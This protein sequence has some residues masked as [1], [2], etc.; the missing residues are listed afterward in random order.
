MIGT[1]LAHYEIVALLGKGGMGEVYQARDTKLGREV[2]VK[3]LPAEVAADPERLARFRRE[4]KL[5]ASL[6][7]PNIGALYGIEEADGHFFLVME[8][9]EGEDLSRRL[10]AGALSVDEALSVAV[11][12]AEGLE[13]AHAKNIVHRDLKPANV[14]YSPS[15]RVKL[16]DFGLARAYHGDEA[17]ADP[18]MSPTITAAMTQQGMVLGTAAYM[19]PEQARGK[20]VDRQSDIWAFGVVLYEMLTTHRLFE[21]ETVSDSIG[22]ILHKDPEWARLPADTPP[23]VRQLLIRCLE[24]DR[25]A[26]LHDIAD[27]RATLVEARRDPTGS[28]LGMSGMHEP[29]RDTGRRVVAIALVTA[30]IGLVLGVALSPMLRSTEDATPY[31]VFDLGVDFEPGDEQQNG[32]QAALS[33]DGGAVVYTHAGQLWLQDLAEHEPRALE[34]TEHALAP[35]WAPDGEEI[36][37]FEGGRIWKAPVRGGRP[38]ALCEVGGQLAGGVGAHWGDDGRILFA[39]GSSGVR[40]VSELGGQ[41][42]VLIEPGEGYGDLHEPFALPDGRGVLFVSHPQ[43]RGPSVLELWREG[44]R[45]VL[46]EAATGDRLW[47]PVYDPAGFVLF[48]WTRGSA[49]EGLWALGFDLASGSVQSEPVLLEADASEA[50][51]ARDGTLVYV[52]NARR[53]NE[54]T[55]SRIAFSGERRENLTATHVGDLEFRLS[56]DGRW[57]AFTAQAPDGEGID[58]LWVRDLV[59]GTEVQLTSF[60]DRLV[61]F[62]Q[63]SSDS[64]QI[65]FISPALSAPLAETLVMPADGSQPWSV[66]VDRPA[67]LLPNGDFLVTTG[68]HG[69]PMLSATPDTT[70]VWLQ[71]GNDPETRRF[72]LGGDAMVFPSD[73]SPDG[74]YLLYYTG[75]QGSESNY[76]TRYPEI[77]G[78]W[79]VSTGT[80]VNAETFAPD[81]SAIYYTSDDALY[82]V[83]F[84]DGPTPVLGRPE[85]VGILPEGSRGNIQI[86][87]DNDSYLIAVNNAVTGTG[88]RRGIK[89]VQHWTAKLERR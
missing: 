74:R 47:A 41:V 42:K 2:A 46:F 73:L 50:T 40:S 31:R 13:A 21:G 80:D 26:R 61:F 33:P 27:A 71:R 87:P 30:L 84:E 8:L 15:G 1:Q 67:N 70:E 82:R 88:N 5:L 39:T 10:K 62:P 85:Q 16:L 56:P 83:S 35:F 52:M 51:L 79:K 34:Q 58:H 89:V 4:A 43:D 23:Q 17:S 12:I 18:M 78:R 54:R 22:A 7:H 49:T 64:R 14:M 57:L 25:E 45:S 44:E 63:W 3:L 75:R 60:E 65:F 9:A 37:W 11:Q 19:S 69:S 29:A 76:L 32:I 48:R 55:I 77:T 68:P 6:N 28:R 59:R 72:L 24:R 86:H 53:S 81:G 36:G 66:A 38:V 20:N